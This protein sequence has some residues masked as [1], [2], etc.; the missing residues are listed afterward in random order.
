MLLYAF[1][2]V[3]N[4]TIKAVDDPRIGIFQKKSLGAEKPR[5]RGVAENI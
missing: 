1:G 5:R 2:V 4:P 3:F